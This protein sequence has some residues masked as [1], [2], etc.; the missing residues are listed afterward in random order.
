MQLGRSECNLAELANLAEEA[1]QK[2]KKQKNIKR[3]VQKKKNTKK[4]KGNGDVRE[5][6][7]K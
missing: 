3:K 7:I 6:I 1:L 5:A 4:D 2:N